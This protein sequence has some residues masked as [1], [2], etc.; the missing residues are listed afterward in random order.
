MF[1]HE[2]DG[3]ISISTAMFVSDHG[4]PPQKLPIKVVLRRQRRAIEGREGGGGAVVEGVDGEA[5]KHR[6]IS[7]HRFG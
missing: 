5:P 1:L 7:S 3:A 2:D 6:D 4:T